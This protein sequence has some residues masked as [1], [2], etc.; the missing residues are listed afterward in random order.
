MAR[1]MTGDDL[2]VLSILF[3]LARIAVLAVGEDLQDVL[4]PVRRDLATLVAAVLLLTSFIPSLMKKR[5]LVLE[6][7]T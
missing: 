5:E 4:R 2:L 1:K 3:D 6:E 7:E